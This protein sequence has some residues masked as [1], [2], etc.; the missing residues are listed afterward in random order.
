M[1]SGKRK[2]FLL[3]IDGQDPRLTR[4]LMARGKLPNFARLAEA[5]GFRALATVNPA[6]SPVAWTTL[7]T[8]ANP[9]VHGVFDFL[10]PVPEKMSIDLAITKLEPSPGGPPKFSRVRQ[11][12]AFWDIAS[13]AGVP[14]SIVRWPVTFPAERVNGFFLSGLGTPDIQG[15][16]ANY[17]YFAAEPPAADDKNPARVRQLARR[18]DAW[19]GSFEGPLVARL[20]GRPRPARVSFLLRTT[21]DRRGELLVEDGQRLELRQ[22]QWSAALRL[23]FK[24]GGRSV[25]GVVRVLPVELGQRPRLYVSPVEID[26][27]E[28]CYDIC[29][30]ADLTGTWAERI[31]LFHTLGMPEDT[32][33]VTD[34]RF[35]LGEFLALYDEVA[36][37]REAMLELVLERFVEDGGVAAVVFDGLDRV[38]HLFWAA[39]DR[40]HPAADAAWHE[41]WDHVIADE[42]ARMDRVL[43]CVLEAAD[44]DTLVLVFSDHGFE[45]FRKAVHLNYWLATAGYMDAEVGAADSETTLMRAV[46]WDKTSAYAVG[47]GCIYLNLAGREAEGVVPAERAGELRREI[48]ERIEQELVDPETGQRMVREAFVREQIFRG[49]LIDR[50][51]DIVVGFEAGYRASWQTALGGGLRC[52]V[53]PNL[54]PWCGDHLVHPDAVPGVVFANRPLREGRASVYQVAPTVL[55]WLGLP[56]PEYAAQE[57]L[58]I[59]E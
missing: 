9:A 11:I 27:A 45:T 20:I 18:G 42:Y 29:W 37:E 50:A 55:E 30:P 58:V 7:A 59:A 52:L 33:G 31:G 6:Q 4:E 44:Q 23:G 43:G 46:N 22:G 16:L 26:P 35:G 47:F 2:I 34:Y 1:S 36:R 15:G 41:K 54:E 13:R 10:R 3:G 14:V 49:P 39:V 57:A 21:R 32:K 56:R 53:E 24:V 25:S 38:Q 17:L 5:G 28:P 51:P 19:A 40:E 8:G 48:A 12:D